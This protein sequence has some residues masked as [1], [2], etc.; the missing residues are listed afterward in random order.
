MNNKEDN[1]ADKLLNEITKAFEMLR[2]TLDTFDAFKIVFVLLHYKRFNDIIKNCDGFDHCVDFISSNEILPEEYRWQHLNE[3]PALQ[4]FTQ[5]DTS[6]FNIYSCNNAER[7]GG[8]GKPLNIQ[9]YQSNIPATTQKNLVNLFSSLNLT[10]KG[11]SQKEFEYVVWQ[12]EE[13]YINAKDKVYY[14]P[15]S[16]SKLIVKLFSTHSDERIYIPFCGSGNLFINTIEHA[17]A[18]SQ[19]DKEYDIDIYLNGKNEELLALQELRFSTAVVSNASTI[20]QLYY[21]SSNPRILLFNIKYL[22]QDTSEISLPNLRNIRQITKADIIFL[23]PPFRLHHP[24]HLPSK[25]TIEGNTLE[26]PLFYGELFELLDHVQKLSEYGRMSVVIPY[27]VL[28]MGGNVRDIKRFLIESDYLEAVIQLPK[29]IYPQPSIQ[30]AILIINKNKPKARKHKTLFA[31]VESS[32]EGD[33]VTISDEEI[34]RI[35]NMY[36]KAKG[37]IESIVTLEEI[38]QQD[39]DLSPE[40]YIGAFSKEMKELI[41]TRS[42]KY[43]DGICI[44]SSS[45]RTRKPDPDNSNGVPFITARD[46]AMDVIDPYL[47]YDKC[48]LGAPSS[49]DKVLERKCIL[50]SLV[51]NTLKPTIFDPETAY[52]GEP[53]Q[54]DHQDKY[55]G[56]LLGQNIATIIPNDQIVDFEYLYYQLYSPIVKKQVDA[57]LLGA[58]GDSQ[59][60][61]Q[62]L[63]KIVIPVLASIEEQ[64]AITI[65]QKLLLLET[66]NL[67][68]ENFKKTLRIVQEEEKAEKERKQ[69]GFKIASFI[70]HNLNGH[71][72]ILNTV[73]DKF[74]T[75]IENKGLSQEP[76]QE[77]YYQGQ[78]VEQVGSLI[79]RAT[80]CLD[81]MKNHIIN[82]RKVVTKDIKEEDFKQ[83]NLEELFKARIIPQY[84]TNS[85]DFR[86]EFK[87]SPKCEVHLCESEFIGAIENII[88][89]ADVHGFTVSETKYVLAIWVTETEDH[90]QID[91]ANNGNPLPP[92][93][94]ADKLLS[95]GDKSI[96]S[97]G[98]G[99]G[100]AHIDEMIKAHKGSFV[101]INDKN[102]NVHFRIILPKGKK[103]EN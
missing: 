5:I 7:F 34:S 98:S 33:T 11:L 16:L 77:Q 68:H 89:N 22:N 1:K 10:L 65:Q 38:Q 26:I 39:Y 78:S 84:L 59:I 67:R 6:L 18:G 80:N 47:N 64:R 85:K 43:L 60:A 58:G 29:K 24:D 53:D 102:Y 25:V 91:C 73:M 82:I 92:E 69:A 93:I 88:N 81:Q 3:V 103:H 96:E 86:I 4:I 41:K 48:F 90:V 27:R 37:D 31:K 100:G 79:N 62:N 49:N 20:Q 19:Y 87:C 13:K 52:K 40:R 94:T 101:I 74:G 2:K 61:L 15:L 57:L 28:L 95:P 71:I 66:E 70:S 14:M 35:V 99:L 44:D 55:R 76:I 42:G 56:V 36:N 8:T 17:Y 83:V 63:K 9:K 30:T 50:V 46:L 21:P 54:N 23:N 75:F 72:G 97:L 32:L 45:G 51:G 12:C